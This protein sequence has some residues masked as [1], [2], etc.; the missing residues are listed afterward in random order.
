MKRTSKKAQHR[1]TSDSESHSD[2]D[3]SEPDNVLEDYLSNLQFDSDAS[4]SYEQQVLMHARSL[5]S[6][7]Q[8]QQMARCNH[9]LMLWQELRMLERFTRV[10]QQTAV[11]NM[12]EAASGEHYLQ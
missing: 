9:V 12:E 6:I 5:C 10:G 7:Q 2:G 3:S 11:E 8:C 1:Q 4:N